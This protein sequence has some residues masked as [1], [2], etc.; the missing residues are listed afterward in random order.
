MGFTSNFAL[1]D[2]LSRSHSCSA[3]E[4][5]LPLMTRCPPGNAATQEDQLCPCRIERVRVEM[6]VKDSA[7]IFRRTCRSHTGPTYLQRF[8]ALAAG[9]IPHSERVV[10]AK[11]T[12]TRAHGAPA[13]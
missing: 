11:E 9:Q 6:Q 3:F 1:H 12:H 2:P 10:S 13:V 4:A 5:K 7:S 8:L